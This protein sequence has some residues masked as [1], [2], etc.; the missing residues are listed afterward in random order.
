MKLLSFLK[1]QELQIALALIAIVAVFQLV[2]FIHLSVPH[3]RNP[4]GPDPKSYQACNGLDNL[5]RTDLKPL[6][7]DARV[8]QQ[9]YA[10]R[11]FEDDPPTRQTHIYYRV[12]G[13]AHAD[14]TKEQMRADL[15]AQAV[16][17]GWQESKYEPG[18]YLSPSNSHISIS[19]SADDPTL[20]TYTIYAHAP[21]NFIPQGAST[22]KPLGVPSLR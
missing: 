18:T 22:S 4:F 5:I 13:P 16:A 3:L 11:R 2:G 6:F 14:Q 12:T 8:A 7:K 21:G 17:A 20:G 1:R 9:T 10:C 19:I 15:N